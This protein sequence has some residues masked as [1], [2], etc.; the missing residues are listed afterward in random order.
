MT[1]ANKRQKPGNRLVSVTTATVTVTPFNHD[2][3]VILFNRA[4][5]VTATLPAATGSGNHFTFAVAKTL[6]GN[7][8]IQVANTTDVIRGGIT[9]QTDT[10]G[11]TVPTTATSDT[12]TMNGS[13]QGG[14]I[15]SVVHLTDF[16]SGTYLVEG[17]LISTGAES[18]PFSAAV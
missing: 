3:K 1:Y 10:S 2:E 15:G 12:I 7:G 5:G 8:V 16:A 9:L 13:T 14:I 11:I 4:A 6:T 17:N 18:T